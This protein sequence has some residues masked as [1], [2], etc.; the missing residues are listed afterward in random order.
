M[1]R[2]PPRSTLFP[3]T[4]LFRSTEVEAPLEPWPPSVDRGPTRTVLDERGR[5]IAGVLGD[6]VAGG[7]PV[8]VVCADVSRRLH[9]LRGRL[10]GFSLCSHAALERAPGLARGFAHLVGLDPPA[11]PH[12]MELLSAAGDGG[13]AHLA[14]GEP[15]LRFAQQIHELEP[16][17]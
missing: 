2:R 11:H 7:E 9:G 10:G 1:I 6:L 8:L 14:W 3:Y 12:G 17:L 4:T 15:E 16:G 13:F 5:G